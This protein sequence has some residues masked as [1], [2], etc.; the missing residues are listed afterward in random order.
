MRTD[1]VE[2]LGA[3]A[4]P[5]LVVAG[6]EDRALPP[7]RSERIARGIPRARLVRVEGA[8]H[9]STIE[10]PERT[11]ELVRDFLASID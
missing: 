8:G 7:K 2:R 3:I 1:F 11:T 6:G 9:L 10:Q 4:T 5:T